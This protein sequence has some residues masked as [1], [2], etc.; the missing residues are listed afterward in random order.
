MKN[1]HREWS[2]PPRQTSIV[3]A[4][5]PFPTPPPPNPTIPG[6]S[7]PTQARGEVRHRVQHAVDAR[8]GV[9]RVFRPPRRGAGWPVRRQ[10]FG[11]L[12]DSSSG[13]ARVRTCGTSLCWPW[14]PG[15]TPAALC[16]LSA[17]M[18]VFSTLWRDVTC[19]PQSAREKRWFVVPFPAQTK[20]KRVWRWFESFTP[21]SRASQPFLSQHPWQA[22]EPILGNISTRGLRVNTISKTKPPSK[23]EQDDRGSNQL[24][25][26]HAYTWPADRRTA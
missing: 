17:A 3:W 21:P 23:G 22:R 9:R 11:G 19:R 6:R 13:G 4:P 14:S 15:D 18:F 20:A 2:L 10:A 12:R 7:L 26:Y 8:G 24:R 16:A 25:C 1:L 5:A